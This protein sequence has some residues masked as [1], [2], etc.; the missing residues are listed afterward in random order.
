MI[1]GLTLPDRLLVASSFPTVGK[2][3]VAMFLIIHLNVL[4]AHDLGFTIFQKILVAQEICAV[5][6]FNIYIYIY[7]YSDP[8][9]GLY[10]DGSFTLLLPPMK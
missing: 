4:D 8:F 1:W 6:K 9:L 10:K 2:E 3:H 5:L 7:F